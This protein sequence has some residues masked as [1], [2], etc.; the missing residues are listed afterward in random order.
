MPSIL[1]QLCTLKV[2]WIFPQVKVL[3]TRT[4]PHIH[5]SQQFN[6]ITK[7]LGEGGKIVN[8]LTLYSKKRKGKIEI[9]E[10]QRGVKVCAKLY[11]ESYDVGGHPDM[12]VLFLWQHDIDVLLVRSAYS[13]FPTS[14]HQH[15]V[16]HKSMFLPSFICWDTS[17]DPYRFVFRLTELFVR[18][19][20][21]NC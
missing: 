12:G 19:S 11:A 6:D 17:P 15:H 9:I 5:I 21:M 8:L 7:P 1:L 3:S 16:L 2:H 20:S 13:D 4:C 18:H 14:F 10:R